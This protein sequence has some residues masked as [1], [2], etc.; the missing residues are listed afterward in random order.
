[1]DKF[2]RRNEVY[3]ITSI[4]DPQLWKLEKK[5]EFP[6]RRRLTERTVAWLSSEVQ[7]WM[8]SRPASS[9]DITNLKYQDS[10]AA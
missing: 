2:I 1:M 9:G 3:E 5:G 6:R 7:E 8:D 4:K 10:V